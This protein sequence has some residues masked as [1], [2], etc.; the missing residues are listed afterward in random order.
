MDVDTRGQ[1]VG[2]G[3]FGSR[4][5]MLSAVLVMQCVAKLPPSWFSAIAW[6]S[7]ARFSLQIGDVGTAGL[8]PGCSPGLMRG[9]T[10]G[11]SIQ[12]VARDPKIHRYCH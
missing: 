4:T 7:S 2:L 6:S 10:A 5:T 9:Y 11:W 12:P 3:E 1:Q 8:F